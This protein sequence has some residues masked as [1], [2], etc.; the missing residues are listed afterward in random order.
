[1][2]YKECP[3]GHK[4][5]NIRVNICE[6]C[7]RNILSIP[8]KTDEVK[9]DINFKKIEEEVYNHLGKNG[10]SQNPQKAFDILKSYVKNNDW[11]YDAK[12]LLAGMYIRGFVEKD[13]K[14]AYQLI[15]DAAE[16][17][18]LAAQTQ[19]GDAYLYGGLGV[20]KDVETG[21]RWLKKAGEKNNSMAIESL[22]SYYYNNCKDEENCNH[23]IYWLNKK[24]ESGNYNAAWQLG[25]IY[26]SGKYMK[27]ES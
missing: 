1:M 23:I 8:T 9:E 17:G 26:F 5:Y 13:E 10:Y 14:E 25:D 2:I 27:E 19:L 18:Q 16:H 6:N 12:T 24:L 3:C 20:I 22:L 11:N 15:I 21:I 4:N 7:G